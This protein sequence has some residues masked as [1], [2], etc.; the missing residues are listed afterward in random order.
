MSSTTRSTAAVYLLLVVTAVALI[1]TGFVSAIPQ[2]PAY[3]LFADTRGWLSIANFGDVLSNLPFLVIGLAGITTVRGLRLELQGS[4]P[5]YIAFFIGVGLTGI[6]SSYFHLAPANDTLLWDRLPMT[7]AFMPL[8]TI[9]I[10]DF[11]SAKAGSRLLLPLLIVGIGSVFYWHWTESIGAGDLR[12]YGLVQFLPMLLIP[13]IL[14]LFKSGDGSKSLY[15]GM[16]A[17]YVLAKLL[18]AADE[19]VFAITGIVSGH[20]LK[21]LAAAGAPLLLLLDI[22]RR[23]ARQAGTT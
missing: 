9:I 14:T 16:I 20:T 18:E 4:W 12:P 13:L 17:F 15:W 10:G 3:Y 1:A 19:Q 23:F 2:D 21:H 11:V 5:A 7:I 6:G 8:F 22:R